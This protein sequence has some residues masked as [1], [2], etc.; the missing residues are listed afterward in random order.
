[1]MKAPKSGIQ[2]GDTVH[3]IG[4]NILGMVNE[5]ESIA[6]L[7]GRFWVNV[8]VVDSLGHR[9]TFSGVF[10]DNLIKYEGGKP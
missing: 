2:L 6:D 3:L 9:T 1:M 7:R 8:T 10:S 5:I 4:S